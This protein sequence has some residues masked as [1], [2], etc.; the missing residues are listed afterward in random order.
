MPTWTR[1]IQESDLAPSYRE[2]RRL[3]HLLTWR[4]PVPTGGH[5]VLKCPQNSRSL[6]TLID[7][8]PE[9]RLVF[10]HRDPFR[11]WI[12][13]LTLVD[14]ITSAF[15]IDDALWRPD[16]SAVS[17][18]IESGELALKCMMTLEKTESDRVYNVAYPA[19]VRE[20]LGIVREIYRRFGVSEPS[21]LADRIK[22]L[23]A[24]QAHGK[25]AAP[26]NDIGT[27]GLE[28]STL[29]ARPIVEDYCALFGVAPEATRITG[30]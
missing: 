14:H 8:L 1:W 16:G 3:I 10:T 13:G 15:R 20:P 18:V 11:A 5:L 22:N 6:Q 23:L 28:P 26:A 4:N 17:S 24:G 7:V 29:L 19:L 9:A 27:Y 25:R 12:S 21:D 30:M 2:H